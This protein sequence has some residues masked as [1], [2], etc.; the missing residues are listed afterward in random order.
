MG[1]T[2]VQP[3]VQTLPLHD[4][5]SL[6]T[7]SL[8][9]LQGFLRQ[10]RHKSSGPNTGLWLSAYFDG[11]LDIDK[12][13]E[14]ETLLHSRFGR[15]RYPEGSAHGN[16]HPDGFFESLTYLDMLLNQLGLRSVGKMGR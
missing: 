3:A 7:R 12:H 14:Y 16:E 2:Q 9:H 6:P 5:P 15:W 13:V 1:T 11:K 4:F 10:P 8:H